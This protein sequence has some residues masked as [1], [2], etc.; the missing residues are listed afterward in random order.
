[1]INKE[2][3]Y[4]AFGE[5]IFAILRIDGTINP[6]Q[7][8]KVEL[9]LK[10]FENGDQI[11]WSFNYENNHKKNWEEIENN[12]LDLF[13]EF[14]PSKDY[15]TFFEIFEAMEI[16]KLDLIGS[17]GKKM[18]TRFKNKLKLKFSENQEIILKLKKEDEDHQDGSH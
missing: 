2:K 3:I 13:L 4:E 15:Q 8:N 6:S 14:G 1:M 11:F 16:E 10:K 9:I 7:K 17:K 18:I 12:T 5:L